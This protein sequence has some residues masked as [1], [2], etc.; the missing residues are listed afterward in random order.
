MKVA[1]YLTWAGEFAN[2]LALTP[3]GNAIGVITRADG[4]EETQTWRRDGRPMI[5]TAPDGDRLMLPW[6]IINLRSTL[7]RIAG[8][9]DAIRRGETR[10]D[11]VD[12][13]A[14]IKTLSQI[15]LGDDEDAVD[16]EGNLMRE[17]LHAIMCETDALATWAGL[18]NVATA[19]ER[20]HL[21]AEV[22]L[23]KKPLPNANW[24]VSGDRLFVDTRPMQEGFRR[25]AESING[26]N[27]RTPSPPDNS[28]E[29]AAAKEAYW[30]RPRAPL[31]HTSLTGLD[32]HHV[33]HAEGMTVRSEVGGRVF[34]EFQLGIGVALDEDGADAL[35]FMLA[36]RPR[37]E[38]P[39]ARK[40]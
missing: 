19:M 25:V 13:L 33:Q 17:A 8:L 36:T 14:Q 29:L 22:G 11:R 40:C 3:Q 23:G 15:A 5:L 31:S 10:R 18:P 21:I 37:E 16:K 1:H 32:G 4:S 9:V 26:L 35:Q 38:K 30:R 39:E 28:A 20:L 12:L 2:V 6:S 27:A 24:L 34:V 7:V